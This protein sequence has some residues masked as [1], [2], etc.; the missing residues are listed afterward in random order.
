MNLKNRILKFISK[1][2]SEDIDKKNFLSRNEKRSEHRIK[3]IAIVYYI[4]KSNTE[5]Y[6]NWEDGF[7]KAID[8]LKEDFQIEW[9]NLEDLKPSVEE[10]NKYDLI[11]AKS[12]WDWIVDDYVSSL[13]GLKSLKGIA[14]SCSKP[15]SKNSDIWKYDIIWYE[16][17]G[18]KKYI[19]KHPNTYFAFGINSDVFKPEFVDKTIDVLSIGAVTSYKRFDKLNDF[20]G[21]KKVIVG[22][23]KTKDFLTVKNQL[24][25]NIEIIDYLPQTD[26][27]N[28]INQSKV[29]YIPCGPQG[30]GERAVLEGLACDAK[31]IVEDDNPKLKSLIEIKKLTKQDYYNSLVSS[32]KYSFGQEV[33]KTNSILSSSN[34]KAGRYSFFNKNF[35]IKGNI[36]VNIGSFCSFGEN[37][38][39][40]TENNDTNY[41]ATQGYVYRALLNQ[42]HPGEESSIKSPERTKGPI[43]IGNDVWIGD[44]VFVMSG[45]TIGDGACIAAGSI[46]TKDVD[47]YSIVGGIPA[48]KIKNRFNTNVIDFLLQLEWWNWTDY[49]I[50]QNKDFFNL[51]LNATPIEILK[52][53]V[54]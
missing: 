9:F 45:V 46:V 20:P 54:K 40:F 17:F 28:L 50:S 49:R 39:F 25:N 18:Y 24:D 2:N 52:Q 37:V 35:K 8:L 14:V 32:I 51:N 29:V 42:N 43:I 41:I 3:S 33:S 36:R 11:I 6:H 12:C 16:T 31:V 22:S 34:V 19:E 53:A 26:L 21:V 10:L 1:Y 30:G 44:N 15:P 47:P 5:K 27:A 23:T 13:K 7:T 38:V 48:K 4:P